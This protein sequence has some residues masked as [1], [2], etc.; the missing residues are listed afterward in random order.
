M[1]TALSSPWEGLCLGG[2]VFLTEIPTDRD[3]PGQRP[4]EGTWNQRQKPP[5]RNM[6][7][8]SQTRSDIRPP[9]CRAIKTKVMVVKVMREFIPR[10]IHQTHTAGSL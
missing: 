3:L 4:R 9:T 10:E 8:G 1:R 6:G 7:P 5:R 2:R